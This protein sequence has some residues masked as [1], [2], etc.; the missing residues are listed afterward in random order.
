MERASARKTFRFAVIESASFN[1]N[2]QSVLMGNY[3][4]NN[5]LHITNRYDSIQFTIH[6]KITLFYVQANKF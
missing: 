1:Q 3:R 5:N 4:V 2:F 6:N